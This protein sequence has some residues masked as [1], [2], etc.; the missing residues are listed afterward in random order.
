MPLKKYFRDILSVQAFQDNPSYIPRDKKFE[1]APRK[2]LVVVGVRRCG[3]ST[4]LQ[5]IADDLI[6]TGRAT[7]DDIVYIH[8]ADERLTQLKGQDLGIILEVLE[9]LRPGRKKFYLFFDEIQFVDGWGR[10][11]ERL[12]RSSRYQVYLSGSNARLLSREI[13]T[14]MRGRSISEELFPLSFVEKL[15]WS[16]VPISSNGESSR[17]AIR[18][19]FQEYRRVGGFPEVQGFGEYLWRKTLQ[20]YLEV[21]LLRDIIERHNPK[22]PVAVGQLMRIFLNQT[23]SLFTINRLFEKLKQT[24]LRLEKAQISEILSWFEDCYF[25]F[26]VP[27]FSKSVS[28]QEIN[29]RK[30]YSIDHGL[31]RACQAGTDEL[32]SHLL[33]NIAFLHLRKM[34]QKIF[35][36]KTRTGHEVDFIVPTGKTFRL[37]QVCETLNGVPETRER[38]IRALRSA[39]SELDLDKAEIWTADEDTNVKTP[40]GTIE[41]KALWRVLIEA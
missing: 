10:F 17:A 35:Y 40:E 12:L 39:M 14:E 13:A 2:A 25:F 27:I 21:M 38:E 15:K 41:V 34:E 33:E 18:R 37:I 36:Y 29:P 23:G 16:K 19:V 5:Q 3:K 31:V 9:E 32:S 24:G 20:E 28:K 6:S 7:I 26:H 4:F 11:V 8:F 22:N 1:I 30:I